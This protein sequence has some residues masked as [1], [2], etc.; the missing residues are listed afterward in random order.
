MPDTAYK[1]LALQLELEDTHS[2]GFLYLDEPI[3]AVVE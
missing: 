2:S 3:H 1:L